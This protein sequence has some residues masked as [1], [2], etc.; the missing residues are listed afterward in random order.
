MIVGHV[1]APVL[2]LIL[3]LLPPLEL[4]E[5]IDEKF[6]FILDDELLVLKL[7]SLDLRIPLLSYFKLDNV[8]Y[9]LT[10][11]P[12]NLL[13]DCNLSFEFELDSRLIFLSI[14]VLF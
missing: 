2:L 1:T 5:L 14:L 6:L 7:T 12:L 3:L 8:V 11:P 9:M 4:F 10:L 13:P